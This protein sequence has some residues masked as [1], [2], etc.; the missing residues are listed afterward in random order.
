MV[1][2]YAS[3]ADVTSPSTWT[4]TT[5][6]DGTNYDVGGT[7]TTVAPNRQGSLYVAFRLTTDD[8]SE[9]PVFTGYQVRAVPAPP[10]SELVQVPVMMFDFETD[11][12]G[13]RYGRLGGAWERFSHLK[14]L[15]EA[16]AT[17]TW[18]D[19]TTGERAEAYVE[20]V[21]LVRLTPPSR[22]FSG[23]GGICQILLRL[24]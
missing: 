22:G 2:G 7:L 11:R 19:H 23:A 6:V 16:A 24:V 3:L 5:T 10:R 13:G 4:L 18:L 14:Q 17:V 12:N 8:T 1:R 15:E 21:V 9:S 20:R